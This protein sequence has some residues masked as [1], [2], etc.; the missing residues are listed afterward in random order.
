MQA[1]NITIFGIES[2]SLDAITVN[3]F[4]FRQQ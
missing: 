4:L 3:A 2:V 1:F